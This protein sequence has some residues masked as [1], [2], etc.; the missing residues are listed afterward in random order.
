[1][2]QSVSYIGPLAES[3]FFFF[4]YAGIAMAKNMKKKKNA[5]DLAPKALWD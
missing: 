2:F 1:M 5:Y 4:Y 3:S